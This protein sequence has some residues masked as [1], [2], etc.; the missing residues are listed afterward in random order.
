MYRVKQSQLSLLG[1]NALQR[2]HEGNACRLNRADF[3]PAPLPS[4]DIVRN[5]AKFG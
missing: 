4:E 3:K 5:K 1:S 2:E